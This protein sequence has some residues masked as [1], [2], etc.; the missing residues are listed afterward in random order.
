METIFYFFEFF[1]NFEPDFVNGVFLKI[2]T[3]EFPKFAYKDNQ[4]IMVFVTTPTM[5]TIKKERRQLSDVIGLTFSPARVRSC[6]DINWVN[7]EVEEKCDVSNQKLLEIKKEEYPGVPVKPERPAYPGKDAGAADKKKYESEKKKYKELRDAY[8]VALKEYNKYKSP[9]YKRLE[10]AHRYSRLLGKL[11]ALLAKPSHSVSYEYE[12]SAV[13]ASLEDRVT[14]KKP[15]ESEESFQARSAKF[16]PKGYTAL[17][18][19]NADLSTVSG[20]DKELER[21]FKEH[22]DLELFSEKDTVAKERTR[23]NDP[24]AVVIA[25]FAQHIVEELVDHTIDK[26]LASRKKIMQPDHCV[27]EGIEECSLFPLI[28]NSPHYL[29]VV[30]RQK[31]KEAYEHKKLQDKSKKVRSDRLRAK[32]E[33]KTPARST[34]LKDYPTFQANEVAS[35][36]ALA[37]TRTNDKG[38]EK[39]HYLWYGIDLEKNPEDE[40]RINFKFYVDKVTK[41]VLDERASENVLIAD[42]KISSNLK[43]FLSDVVVDFIMRITPLAMSLIESKK[44]KT[45]TEEVAMTVIKQ[46]LVDSYSRKKVRALLSEEHSKMF[47][48]VREKVKLCQE[49]Q[50]GVVAKEVEEPE[51]EESEDE[52]LGHDADPTELSDDDLG[53]NE[54]EAE[55]EPVKAAAKPAAKSGSARKNVRQN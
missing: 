22:R 49:H 33:G 8:I 47:D 54:A 44:V 6:M 31:R 32:K 19:S 21:V 15:K 27:S 1:S 29:A 11:K 42:I 17:R 50:T 55:P 13:R 4:E 48:E 28:S 43:K 18:S 36:Y 39:E 52:D 12:L 24:A 34:A 37:E 5:A 2:T 40:Q 16:K 26:T 35:G 30:A 23:F 7:R 41:D 14:P 46:L 3:S 25:N 45:I 38:K 51:S 53:E 20:V 10:T 9:R